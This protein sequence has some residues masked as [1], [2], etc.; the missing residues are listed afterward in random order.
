MERQR[1]RL[2][3]ANIE[4]ESEILAETM[5]ISELKDNA[6]KYITALTKKITKNTDTYSNQSKQSVLKIIATIHMATKHLNN[7]IKDFTN[8]EKKENG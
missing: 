8:M 1:H 3:M 5:S 6:L 7:A 2:T 4:K